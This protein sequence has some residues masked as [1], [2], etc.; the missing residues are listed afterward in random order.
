MKFAQ[1][2]VKEQMREIYDEQVR[3]NQEY[4][5]KQA[6]L[7]R[8]QDQKY[9]S[10]FKTAKDKAEFRH[11]TGNMGML[12]SKTQNEIDRLNSEKY[13]NLEVWRKSKELSQL[14]SFVFEKN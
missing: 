7:K 1:S 12:F 13:K 9:L 2:V 11:T 10:Q 6:E 8:L 3:A 14:K 4:L 5:D